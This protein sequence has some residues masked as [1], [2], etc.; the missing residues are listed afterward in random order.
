MELFPWLC[1]CLHFACFHQQLILPQQ[2]WDHPPSATNVWHL[3]CGGWP[4]TATHRLAG[5]RHEDSDWLGLLHIVRK[6]YLLAEGDTDG[7]AA[8]SFIHRSD[9]STSGL[10]SYILVGI[11]GV[12]CRK[13]QTN[14]KSDQ[15]DRYNLF[16]FYLIYSNT[17][18][19]AILTN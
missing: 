1:A 19:H 3:R 18:S 15:I 8:D 14:V 7:S 9:L 5:Q 6:R 10:W 4:A 13:Q 12:Q 17:F 2:V 16:W 11:V